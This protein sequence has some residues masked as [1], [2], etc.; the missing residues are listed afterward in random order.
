MAEM[1][2]VVVDPASRYGD[3]RLGQRARHLTGVGGG[4][5]EVFLVRE[6]GDTLNI[7]CQVCEMTVFGLK[8]LNNHINGKKHQGKFTSQV[9]AGYFCHLI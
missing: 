8:N 2:P 9:S 1:P 4:V 5:K 3:L 6:E 7:R